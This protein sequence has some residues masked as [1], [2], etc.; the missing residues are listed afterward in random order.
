MRCE[1][2]DE[3]GILNAVFEDWD[4]GCNFE[5]QGGVALMVLEIGHLY[6]VLV[7]QKSKSHSCDLF[8]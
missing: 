6:P 2:H 1:L 7:Y 5:G 8:E 3:G 4:G